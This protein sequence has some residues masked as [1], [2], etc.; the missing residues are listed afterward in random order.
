MAGQLQSA[1]ENLG[2][3]MRSLTTSTRP[4]SAAQE[5]GDHPCYDA[6]KDTCLRGDESAK[7]E[8]IEFEK[9]PKRRAPR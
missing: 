5:Q 1:N 3:E 8:G 2:W 7:T 6:C 4:S 9:T